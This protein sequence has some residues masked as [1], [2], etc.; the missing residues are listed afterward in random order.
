MNPVGAVLA[1]TA[2]WLTVLAAY[3]L[4][5]IP[6]AICLALAWAALAGARRANRTRKETR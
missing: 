6:F 3:T 2:L 5:T 4:A 1:F